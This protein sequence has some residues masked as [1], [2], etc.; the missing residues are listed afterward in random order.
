MSLP[1]N[2]HVSAHPCLQAKLSQLRS[3]STGNRDVQTLVHEIALM[4]GYE[5]LGSAL[6]P[7]QDGSTVRLPRTTYNNTP[8]L[9]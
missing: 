3:A 9:I 5:A 6:K 1:H 4:V 8:H 2:A 7:T